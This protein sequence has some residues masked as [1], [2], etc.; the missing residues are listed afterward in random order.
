[1]RDALSA[2]VLLTTLLAAAAC[3]P[4][5]AAD[6]PAD[7]GPEPIDDP[8][9]QASPFVDD[10]VAEL[11]LELSAADWAA[12][13]ADPEAEAWYPASLQYDDTRLE[14]VM[15]RVK[16]NSSLRSVA[17]MG[18]HRFSFKVDLDDVV[19]GQDLLG[20][21][22]LILNNGF[23]DP[24]LLREA[25]AY[26]V[27]RAAGLPASRTA[28]VDLT[29]AD[30]HLGVYTLVEDVGGDFLDDHFEDGNGILYKPEPPAGDL[31]WRGA[32]FADYPGLE[33]ERHEELGHD[34]FLALVAALDAGDAAALPAVLDVDRALSY[35]AVS[36]LLAN[37]DSYLGTAHNYY[38]YGAGG[39]FT[40]IPWDMN[41]AFGNFACGCDRDGII[42]L[43]IEEPTCAP[44]ASRPLVAK[45]LADPELAT[46][47]RAI[48]A[49]LTDGAFAEAAMQARIDTLAALI[50]P[51]VEADTDKF[52]T[53][54]E[55]EQGLESDVQGGGIGLLA[56]VRERLEAVAAQ[57]AGD[58]P[59]DAAGLGGCRGGG[60]GPNPCGD[61]VCDQAEQNN[62]ALCPADC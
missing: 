37:L 56:F 1:M 11:H 6:P 18:S 2:G 17:A 29:V 51:A 60:G 13:L 40:V 62:P 7:A 16:G 14:Q 47:Y 46:R 32:T 39:V 10:H 31:T 3:D 27:A 43:P 54:E 35:L 8:S 52:F 20:E 22:K 36:G 41:E 38:L 30:E 58:A 15:V 23:K 9:A 61:G 12:L 34:A 59:A 57:L 53:T 45:L 21:S 44:A 50:R 49:E 4:D 42:A 24:T 25:L 48:V 19:E 5:S 28:F 26:G 55:F 33:V